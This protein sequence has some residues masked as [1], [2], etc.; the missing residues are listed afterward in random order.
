MNELFLITNPNPIEKI[1][2]NDGILYFTLSGIDK[3]FANGLRRTILS[4][5]PTVV[6]RSEDHKTNQC[7][8]KK[9]TSRLHNEIIQHRISCIPIHTNDPEFVNNY[10]MEMDVSND[11]EQNIRMVT[12]EDIRIK[13]IENNQYI[14]QEET[15][16]IFPPNE[17]TGR[18]IDIVRLR[19]KVGKMIPGEQLM[20]TAK[21][22]VATAR[23]NGMFNVVSK[24]SYGYTPDIKKIQDT[25]ES[26][27]SKYESENMTREEIAHLKNDFMHLD[28]ERI[29]HNNSFDFVVQTI[30]VYKNTDIVHKAC[31]FLI[32]KFEE[33]I[34]SIEKDNIPILTSDSSKKHGF[35]SVI[36]SSVQ[37]SFDIILEN[38]DDTMG[39]I[40]SHILYELYFLGKKE[41]ELSFCSFKKFHPHDAYS[42]LRIAYKEIPTRIQITNHL[43][44]AANQARL[45]FKEI[46]SMFL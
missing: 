15:K 39:N 33:F 8:I 34:L 38:E 29:F 5:I 26:L 24:S 19:P 35:H 45:V 11:S 44:I 23:I 32:H 43:Q 16:Q 12:T 9:N 14:S 4:D 2:E 1:I 22:S 40:L 17:I 3:C 37:N 18:Y 27:E 7:I 36:E 42:V 41:A 21:F 10:I 13:H 30:G 46:R 28:A 6:V 31:S 20:L 25:W